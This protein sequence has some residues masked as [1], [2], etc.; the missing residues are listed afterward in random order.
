[1]KGMNQMEKYLKDRI[2][3]L[4]TIDDMLEENLKDPEFAREYEKATLRIALARA[5]RLAREKS[6]LTQAQLADQLGIKQAQ[7][8]RLEGSNDKSLPGI[9]FLLNI[10]AATGKE[11][12]VDSHG[13][14]LRIAK[15]RPPS[16]RSPRSSGSRV[17]RAAKR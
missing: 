17:R 13:F 5:A 6:G 9:D 11:I 4:P 16:G 1:M 3:D 15:K 2:K 10:A 14:N 12:R 8:G 7:I